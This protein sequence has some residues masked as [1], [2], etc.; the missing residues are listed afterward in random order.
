MSGR[1]WAHRPRFDSQA[2]QADQQHEAGLQADQQAAQADQQAAQMG[3]EQQMAA[4]QPK[5]GE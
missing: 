1:Q 2:Q 3:H 4:Q 5:T